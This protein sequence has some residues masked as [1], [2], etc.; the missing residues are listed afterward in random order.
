AEGEAFKPR[1][2]KILSAGGSEAP[3]KILGDAGIDIRSAAFWQGGFDVIAA[4][5]DEL[6]KL[7]VKSGERRGVKR[8]S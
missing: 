3:A 2:L 8:N 1:Y 7:S 6:E 4:L 5:V